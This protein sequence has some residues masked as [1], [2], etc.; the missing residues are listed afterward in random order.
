MQLSL[1][2]I[3]VQ[4]LKSNLWNGYAIDVLRLDMVHPIVSGNKWF[5]L[6]FHLQNALVQNK[7]TMAS[8]GGAYSNHIIALAYA[9]HAEGLKS[10]GIIRGQKPREMSATLRSAENFGMQLI[11]VSREDFKHKNKLEQE[12]DGDYYWINEGGYSTEGMM[13]ASEILSVADTTNYSHIICSCGTGTMIA[14][15]INAALPHQ[16]IIGINALKGHM[17]LENDIKNLLPKNKQQRNFNILN[18][19]HFGG[20]AKH[21]TALIDWMKELW[22]QENLPTDIV[23]TS[24]LLYAVKDLCNQNTFAKNSRLLIIHSGGLQGNLSLPLNTLPF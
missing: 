4:T 18:E 5:K 8:Y 19:Y 14:G 22:Q 7:K 16:K 17:G 1:N 3:E 15:L 13:G 2:K 12:F 20:Y 9:C 6:K 21:T 24:K 23:Y 11:F 10:V